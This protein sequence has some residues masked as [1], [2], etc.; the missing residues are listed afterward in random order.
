MSDAEDIWNSLTV[1]TASI[2]ARLYPGSSEVWLGVDPDRRRHLLVR[3]SGE[4]VGQQLMETRGLQA[5]T[6]QL[7]IEDGTLDTWVD[8]IC[9]E[10]A[11]DDTFS[12]VAEDLVE[13][14][15]SDPVSPMHGV[16]ET[17]RR[18]RWFW[19]V[20]SSGMSDEAALGLFGE[21]W[22]LDRWTNPSV[23]LQNWLGPSGSRHDFVSRSISIEVKATQVRV[24]GPGRH[25]ITSLDQLDDSESGDLYLFSL[26]V[27]KDANAANTLLG[28]VATVRSRM[29]HDAELVGLFDRRLAEAGWTPAAEKKHG[30][31]YRV[32]GEELY[33]VDAGFPRLTRSSFPDGL[34][35]GIDQIT[36]TVD[37]A[38]CAEKRVAKAPAEARAIL[39][40]LTP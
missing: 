20:D 6:D 40:A 5:S 31:P 24:D 22:F 10:S 3:A 32:T 26:T 11:L 15:R 18:W 36:Y 12:A 16:R 25:R 9:L 7:A 28:L 29:R 19:G 23:S 14:T 2:S 17:L 27:T 35:T 38:A 34:P 39:D 13:E 21:L 1:P 33:R 8:I 37:L 30:Q 4:D